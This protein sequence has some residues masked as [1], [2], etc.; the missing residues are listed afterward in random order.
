MLLLLVNPCVREVRP[1]C[2][3]QR[4]GRG[5]PQ[6]TSQQIDRMHITRPQLALRLSYEYVDSKIYCNYYMRARWLTMYFLVL[7]SHHQRKDHVTCLSMLFKHYINLFLFSYTKN[8]K[9][10]E[11]SF[12]LCKL[13]V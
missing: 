11:M 6:H 4:M 10:S 9:L 1:K 3:D 7:P 8:C 12:E 2:R 13:V 5:F